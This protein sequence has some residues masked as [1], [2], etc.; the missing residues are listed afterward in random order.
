MQEQDATRTEN[1]KEEKNGYKPLSFHG[2]KRRGGPPAPLSLRVFTM[3]SIK[4]KLLSGMDEQK[5][6]I[7]AR[8]EKMKASLKVLNNELHRLMVQRKILA[9]KIDKL[10]SKYRTLVDRV[11]MEDGTERSANN[12]VIKAAQERQLLELELPKL[13]E[14]VEKVRSDIAKLEKATGEI[15]QSNNALCTS[16]NSPKSIKLAN[17]QM[18]L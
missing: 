1:G 16:L 12:Y 17:E 6:E 18:H 4:Q 9:S 3:E 8:R 5:Q 11:K 2:S 14:E 10:Q 7:N 13:K 15:Q